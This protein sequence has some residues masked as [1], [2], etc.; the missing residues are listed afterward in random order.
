MR[1]DPTNC[2]SVPLTRRGTVEDPPGHG[3]S[4]SSHCPG[5]VRDVRGGLG[6]VAVTEGETCRHREREGLKERE[7]ERLDRVRKGDIEGRDGDSEGGI[8]R[9]R[10]A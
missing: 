9:G 10:E 4:L 2:S 3:N 6:E 1:V 7:K 8:E 5:G